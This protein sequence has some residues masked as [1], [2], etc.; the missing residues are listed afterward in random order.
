[1][2][3]SQL[4]CTGS[5]PTQ[6][7]TYIFHHKAAVVKL[8]FDR[9]DRLF[10]CPEYLSE[11][12][13][14]MHMAMASNNYSRG[15]V[16]KVL[17]RHAVRT[18]KKERKIGIVISYIHG[19]SEAVTSANIDVY[20]KPVTTLRHLIS[21]VKDPTS[22]LQKSG[23]VYCIP[24]RTCS[25]VYVGQTGKLLKTRVDAVRYGKS[26]VSA[27]AE[28]VWIDKHDIDFQSVSVL[29]WEPDIRQ[30]L[31]LESWYIR[32]LKTFNREK[33]VLGTKYNCLF[34]S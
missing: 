20:F 15:F 18:E 2:A 4:E 1:M 32:T 24:C 22:T 5:R 33:G 29:V 34:S 10:S 21:R 23:V 7:D 30:R 11:E 19:I 12:L 3:P 17:N 8:L 9:A 13:D 28:H 14:K 31:S 27:V 6:R 16:K 26:D 25:S